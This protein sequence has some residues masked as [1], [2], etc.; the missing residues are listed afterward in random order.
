MKMI[1]FSNLDKKTI[2]GMIADKNNGMSD[3]LK[4]NTKQCETL[5]EYVE[6]L[7]VFGYCEENSSSAIAKQANDDGVGFEVTNSMVKGTLAIIGAQVK[8]ITQV[9]WATVDYDYNNGG[10]DYSEFDLINRASEVNELENE[11]SNVDSTNEFTKLSE[12][13]QAQLIGFASDIDQKPEFKTFNSYG[14]K[15]IYSDK[16]NSYITNG[17]Y[18]GAMVM[19]GL[20]IKDNLAQ[21]WV[22]A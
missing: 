12:Q 6:D 5:K 8:D 17:A 7:V 10:I 15:H 22:V 2:A 21:N 9:D 1:K 16:F 13:E 20:K 19:A 11:Y 18:K 4:L 3:I 14:L